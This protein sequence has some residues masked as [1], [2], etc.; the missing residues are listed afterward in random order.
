MNAAQPMVPSMLSEL[1]R[2]EMA[3]VKRFGGNDTHIS[4]AETPWV[5]WVGDVEVRILRIE[6][7]TGTFVIGLRSPTDQSLGR[8]RHRGLVNATTISGTWNY[9]EYD[10]VAHPG[11][12]V[13]ETPGTI[14][15]LHVSAGTEIVFTV[16]G[17][18]E[19][20]NADDSLASVWDCFSFVNLY[21][22]FCAARGMQLNQRLF[23]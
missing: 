19:F 7:R 5:P 20:F 17:S 14:H 6:N 18:I 4:A 23:Y 22:Q 12:Y 1:D 2:Q 13:V 11:D 21:A 15:T 8:H 16:T 10:W 3:T 9:Y